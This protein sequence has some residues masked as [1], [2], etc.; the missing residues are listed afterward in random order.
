MR[1]C[2]LENVLYNLG[3]HH[4]KQLFSLA[5]T[6]FYSTHFLLDSTRNAPKILDALNKYHIYADEVYAMSEDSSYD[7]Q[8]K[9]LRKSEPT[10]LTPVTIMVVDTISAVRSRQL[11]RV[12]GMVHAWVAQKLLNLTF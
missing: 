7:R 2:C 1:T 12:L 8:H 4:S 9:K 10:N 6:D 11:L 3:L 5:K